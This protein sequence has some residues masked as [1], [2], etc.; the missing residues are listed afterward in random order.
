MKRA[1]LWHVFFAQFLLIC[2]VYSSEQPH[3]SKR[4][5]SLIVRGESGSL[6]IG[7]LNSVLSSI[8]NDAVYTSLRESGSGLCV[9]EIR[10]VP[11]RFKG[12][13]VELRWM[14]KCF[15]LGLAFASP[16]K[17]YS[18]SHLDYTI[19]NSSAMETVSFTYESKISAYTPIKLSFYYSPPPISG[20]RVV[21]NAGA[22]YYRA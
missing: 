12:W 10:E 22:G 11:N 17:Y 13:E 19:A 14:P 3:V 18:K 2:F 4:A 16:T 20:V 21:L 15:G 8:N 7:D 9:G 1:I 5:F 6:G